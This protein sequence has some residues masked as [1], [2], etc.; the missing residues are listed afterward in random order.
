MKKKINFNTTI[1]KAFKDDEGNMHV[2]AIASDNKPDCENDRMS[3]R[4]ID[5]FVKQCKRG[6]DIL[7]NHRSTF[8]FGVT[9]DAWKE[10]Q[11]DSVSLAIEIL[12]KPE[13]PQSA[14]LFQSV[15][16]GKED[17]QLSI[18][19]WLD[20][21]AGIEY[22]F[23]SAG[24]RVRVIH[25]I[26]LDHVAVTRPG[27]ACN[28][29]AGF[30]QAMI[31]DILGSGAE[32]NPI[33]YRKLLMAV[34]KENGGNGM[35]VSGVTGDASNGNGLRHFHE[36][37]MFIDT[38][39]N[40]QAGET[41]LPISFEGEEA[42]HTHTIASPMKTGDARDHS[43]ILLLGV[44]QLSNDNRIETKVFP[45]EIPVALKDDFELYGEWANKIYNMTA[46]G[47]M[48]EDI[49]YFYAKELS[50]KMSTHKSASNMFTAAFD[51]KS[52]EAFLVEQEEA[53]KSNLKLAISECIA[54]D[55]NNMSE[56]IEKAVHESSAALYSYGAD[57]CKALT[58]KDVELTEDELNTIS[59]AS[60]QASL[61]IQRDFDREV[62]IKSISKEAVVESFNNDYFSVALDSLKSAFEN[63]GMYD[64]DSATFVPEENYS[65]T[66]R[67]I[68][69]PV[70]C[71][72]IE[73]VIL[74]TSN[75][76]DSLE[77]IAKR[78]KSDYV[79]GR[80][81]PA[82]GH[83]H[84]YILR[85][86]GKGVAINALGH[87]HTIKEDFVE[88]SL[89]HSH[90]LCDNNMSE[91]VIP[92]VSFDLADLEAD[93][94]RSTNPEHCAWHNGE[95]GLFSHHKGYERNGATVLRGLVVAS[96]ELLGIKDCDMPCL[97]SDE[98]KA[99]A[100][101]LCKHF[102]EFTI[103]APE[104]LKSATTQSTLDSSKSNVNEFI[105]E[106]EFQGVEMLWFS[107][108]IEESNKADNTNAES[109]KEQIKSKKDVTLLLEGEENMTKEKDKQ[110][111]APEELEAKEEEKVEDIVEEK[112]EE[113]KPEASTE[114]VVE[115]SKED[116]E[117]TSKEEEPEADEDE[118]EAE[119]SDEESDETDED[120]E[121]AEESDE[122]SD[123]TEEEVEEEVKEE[124][125]T[126]SLFTTLVE[127]LRRKKSEKV[128]EE[129]DE[130]E[131]EEATGDESDSS[132]ESEEEAV[133]DATDDTSEAEE[134]AEDKENVATILNFAGFQAAF[135]QARALAL[136]GTNASQLKDLLE[137]MGE[138]ITEKDLVDKSSMNEVINKSI[139]DKVEAVLT[140]FLPGFVSSTEDIAKAV[141]DSSEKVAE[142]QKTIAALENR[143]GELEVLSGGS[144]QEKTDG[145][146]E[147][148][149][150][151]GPG[152]PAFG[153][154]FNN[155]AS[156][157]LRRRK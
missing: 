133:E 110:E 52:V 149:E 9:V 92:F 40:V 11:P 138:F 119:E 137:A 63:V 91:N 122:E 85:N 38:D 121:E 31:K 79:I 72:S 96:A 53:L 51:M 48:P 154:V 50:K 89:D 105:A 130:S 100:R 24:Q 134:E 95:T 26:E 13:Y 76:P 116:E 93:C 98:V 49:Q 30:L 5:G 73:D 22:E 44:I 67:G 62:A 55:C 126:K 128:D 151:E 78:I 4:C 43:H 54:I 8:A 118:E 84:K 35:V 60:N 37:A 77:G 58:G 156:R 106:F 42:G 41:G 34:Q 20:P 143:L 3:A 2:V 142:V 103:E 59:I 124:K 28:Q 83:F 68:D 81:A 113:S 146:E 29:R 6:V 147:V 66:I 97:T 136:G 144:Q 15:L 16:S 87:I 135:E 27:Q 115:E 153:G 132:D 101:H 145:T 102:E 108:L 107:D 64:E 57:L 7:E 46:S 82:N 112:E 99:V 152:T 150:D 25:G 65:F 36:F 131:E 127:K 120:E 74:R 111:K 75:L 125:A 140:D 56:G 70:P 10:D 45:D 12:L 148:E 104:S 141:T 21:D 32:L 88:E 47:E 23:N 94:E 155:A 129:E 117:A 157:A 17:K 139:Q 90:R 14:D 71:G 1:T 86:D 33:K 61:D 80:T 19:G 69:V 39:G 109:S 114:E 123:E 18:G